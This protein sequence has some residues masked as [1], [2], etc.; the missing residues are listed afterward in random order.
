MSKVNPSF[1]NEIDISLGPVLASTSRFRAAQLKT[2]GLTFDAVPPNVDE[3]PLKSET[4]EQLVKRLGREK[5]L[6][7]ATTHPT[8]VVIGG[9]Q[10]AVF[11]GSILG[12]PGSAAAA[13]QQLARFSGH[14]VEFLTHCSVMAG[15]G[16]SQWHHTDHTWVEFR[17]LTEAEIQRYIAL[18]NPVDCAGGF[19]IEGLG[20]TLFDRVRSDDPSALIGLP[21]LFVSRALRHYG[22]A[23]P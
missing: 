2:L 14:R 17:D 4:P 20:V 16:R 9:D 15:A 5:A 10:I 23:L 13:A 3:T 19:K 12:K 22:Y 21:L 18:D 1:L 11:N 7:V 6:A 8:R